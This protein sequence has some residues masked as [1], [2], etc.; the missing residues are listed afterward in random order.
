MAIA[1]VQS[2]KVVATGV[3]NF[4]EGS[5]DILIA[6]QLRA[7]YPEKNISNLY[8]GLLEIDGFNIDYAHHGPY[9][10]SRDWLRGNVASLYLRDIMM[11]SIRQGE[12]PPD[13]V[14]RAH[15]HS[16]VIAPIYV[17]DYFSQLIVSPSYS[18][19]GDHAHQA[20]RSPDTIRNGLMAVELV[21]G[22]L[23]KIHKFI[24]TL[25][26]RTKETL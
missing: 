17:G 1:L 24:H 11:R 3:N 18:L 25:D 7:M 21:D 9:P 16:D 6:E 5:A 12:K 26:V 15:Y 23:I 22:K 20:A 4:L 19:L 10:G 14:L 2:R 8:H 13:L